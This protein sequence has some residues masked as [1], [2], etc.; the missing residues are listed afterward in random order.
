MRNQEVK[1]P[2]KENL[3]VEFSED[4][5]RVIA[6]LPF[7]GLSAFGETKSIAQGRVSMMLNRLF[8]EVNR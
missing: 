8:D 6:K 7:F 2:P 4:R 5:G 1:N 3:V